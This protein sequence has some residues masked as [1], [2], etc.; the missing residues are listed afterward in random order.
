MITAYIIG[1]FVTFITFALYNQQCKIGD[2]IEMS[3]SVFAS[4]A[5]P[6]TA[7]AALIAVVYAMLEKLFNLISKK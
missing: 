4:L 1:F 5:W 6:M 3:V 7:A 2:E